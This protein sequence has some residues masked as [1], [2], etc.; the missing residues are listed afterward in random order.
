MT[1]DEFVEYIFSKIRA[2]GIEPFD[3]YED[4]LRFLWRGYDV[5]YCGRGNGKT[6]LKRE[7]EVARGIIEK[8]FEEDFL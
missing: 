2:K 3:W 1:E 8:H 7:L 6:L 5:H 4:H